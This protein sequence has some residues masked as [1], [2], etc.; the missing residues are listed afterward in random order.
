M[1]WQQTL[2]HRQLRVQGNV[3]ALKHPVQDSIMIEPYERVS[4]PASGS[5]CKLNA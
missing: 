2:S 5:C 1:S 3:T 4:W